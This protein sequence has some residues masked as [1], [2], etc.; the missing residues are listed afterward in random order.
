M[1]LIEQREWIEGY[2]GRWY[3]KKL[4]CKV[5]G[6]KI[7]TESWNETRCF[8]VGTIL[9]DNSMPKYCPTCGTC[10]ESYES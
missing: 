9:A 3:R 5:C 2:Q 1:A 10:I 6:T 7:R 4:F 8:G